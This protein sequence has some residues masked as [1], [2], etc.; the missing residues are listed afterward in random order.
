MKPILLA[1][2][3]LPLLAMT[4]WAF[5]GSTTKPGQT[6]SEAIDIARSRK[7]SEQFAE[8]ADTY[9]AEFVEVVRERDLLSP[10]ESTERKLP[11]DS[12]IRWL[13]DVATSLNA[14]VESHD[15][16]IKYPRV[17][18]VNSSGGRLSTKAELERVRDRLD[19]FLSS[20]SSQAESVKKFVAD[21]RAGIDGEIK[22]IEVIES[23]AT[24]LQSDDFDQCIAQVSAIDRTAEI[25]GV[26]IRL[27]EADR[28]ERLAKFRKHWQDRPKVDEQRLLQTER[29]AEL[30]PKLEQQ[31][32][33]LSQLRQSTPELEDSDT[34]DQIVLDDVDD[35][36][37]MLSIKLR[38]IDDVKSPPTN[39]AEL[40][41][42]I[43]MVLVDFKSDSFARKECQSLFI[44][45]LTEGRLVA[46]DAAVDSKIKQA[47]HKADGLVVGEFGE[48]KGTGN[49][50]YYD[51]KYGARQHKQIYPS[52]L[53]G[54][55]TDP[56]NALC[57]AR[58]NSELTTLLER[59]SSREQWTLFGEA[60]S[61]LD[62]RMMKF[63]SA[64][65]ASYSLKQDSDLIGASQ[66]KLNFAQDAAIAEGV[67]RRFGIVLDMYGE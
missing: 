5:A 41:D 17:E 11:T 18:G 47:V 22:C 63:E 55:V 39:V 4:V 48:L 56:T 8:E 59:P 14:A 35:E 53:E 20:T 16:A 23:A 29:V 67:I 28:L 34:E 21:R 1:A 62:K 49:A 33:L 58:F 31:R 50:Q 54:T 51:F 2:G 15:V 9:Q 24:A 26:K 65:P 42:K 13:N 10:D 7:L 30:S 32:I 60:C 57:A 66:A 6:Q 37:R 27:R 40:L 38:V 52:E 61:E 44:E 64:T 3:F 46:R 19:E 43:E 25:P 12:D 45:W 36:L